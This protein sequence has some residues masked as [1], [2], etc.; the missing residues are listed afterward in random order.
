[1]IDN[2]ITSIN[3]WPEVKSSHA[4]RKL[5]LDGIALALGIPTE[6]LSASIMSSR[7]GQAAQRCSSWQR[8]H[9]ILAVKVC[10]NLKHKQKK[11]HAPQV[12]KQLHPS[13]KTYLCLRRARGSPVLLSWKACSTSGT[14]S[15]ILPFR[16]TTRLWLAACARCKRRI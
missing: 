2:Q 10:I 16:H 14:I 3:A 11:Q 9:P 12:P 15:R 8:S 7:N 6:T 4:K 5:I 1:M 13:N